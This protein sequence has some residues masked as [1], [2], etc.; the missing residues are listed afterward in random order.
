MCSKSASFKTPVQKIQLPRIENPGHVLDIGGGGEG[1]VS[2]IEGT[3]VIAL[4]LN[5]NKIRGAMIHNPASVWIACDGRQLCIQDSAVENV[6]LWFSLSYMKDNDTKKTV[7][8]ESF[9]VLRPGGR[10]SI[11]GCHIGCEEERLVFRAEF[12]L[13]DGDVSKISYAV[14]RGQGQTLDGISRMLVESG[15]DIIETESHEFW[16]R[17]L[18]CKSKI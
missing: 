3:R 15:F 8:E 17:V 11:L 12:Q 18:G 16:F 13:P 2:R 9:R 6:T 14:Y 10:I 4:D 5:M 1:L 7:L